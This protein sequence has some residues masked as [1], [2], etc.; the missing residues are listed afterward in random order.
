MARHPRPDGQRSVGQAPADTGHRDRVRDARV[1]GPLFHR[2]QCTTC[3]FYALPGG[4]VLEK[5]AR[6]EQEGV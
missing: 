3:V 1:R 2:E 4:H 6:G 5:R